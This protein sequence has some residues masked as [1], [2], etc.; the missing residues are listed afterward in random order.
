MKTKAPLI[1]LLLLMTLLTA[2]HFEPLT[3]NTEKPNDQPE[4]L[5]AAASSL[6]PAFKALAT[7]FEAHY[8]CKV[9]FSFASTGTLAEQIKN[10]AP[11]DLFAAANEQ[12]ALKLVDSQDLLPDSLTPYAIGRIGIATLA[13]SPLDI[14]TLED[15]L[16]PTLQVIAIANPDHA[17]YGLAAKEALTHQ[18]LWQPLEA[19]LVFGKNISDTLV[20]LKSGN[21]DVAIISQSLSDDDTLDFELIDDSLHSPLIQTMGIVAHTQQ[22]T[23]AQAFIDFVISDEGQSQLSQFGYS[24]PKE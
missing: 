15:L 23:L 12:D 18:N 24:S 10:G 3:S 5:I 6:T 22:A 4:L 7:S 14:K 11:F 16:S 9:V 2:C 8:P 13:S 19:K 1:L 20:Y 21:A 17:P